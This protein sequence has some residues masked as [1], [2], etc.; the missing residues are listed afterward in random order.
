LAE[1]LVGDPVFAQSRVLGLGRH[2]SPN[3]EGASMD[4]EMP[5]IFRHEDDQV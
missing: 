5:R 4:L 3:A 1:D 2:R